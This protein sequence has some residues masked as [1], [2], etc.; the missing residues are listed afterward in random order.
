LYRDTNKGNFL[1]FWAHIA[2]PSAD[3]YSIIVYEKKKL[4]ANRFPSFHTSF[5]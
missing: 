3:I 2:T 1:F 5:E 4:H